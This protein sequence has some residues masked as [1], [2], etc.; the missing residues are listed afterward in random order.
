[1]TRLKRIVLAL[2]LVALIG[3]MAFDQI[4]LRLPGIVDGIRHPTGPNREVDWSQGPQTAAQP[5]DQRPPNIVVI[6]ADDLGWND[7]TF[8][9][10]GVAGGGMPTPNID[11]IARDGVRFSKAYSGSGTC[12][13]SRAAIMSG[14]Y[15]T[16]FGFEFTPTPK[17]MS[18]LRSR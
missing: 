7:L 2:A 9:G 1:M 6:V 11:S 10:G 8:G 12:A 14:R 16:R 5:A 3:W 15:P 17:Q 13:A 4:L 18:R